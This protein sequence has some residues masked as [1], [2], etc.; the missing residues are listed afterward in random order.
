MINLD[1]TYT[2]NVEAPGPDYTYGAFRNDSSGVAVDGTPIERAFLND[3]NG[4]FQSLMVEAGI[5]PSNSPETVGVS[6]IKDALKAIIQAD[7]AVPIATTLVA[8]RSELATA[9]EAVNPAIND[10]VIT[11]LGLAALTSSTTRKGLIQTATN[12]NSVDGI[13][14]TLA[15]TPAGLQAKLNTLTPTTGAVGLTKYADGSHVVDRNGLGITDRAVTPDALYNAF[16]GQ[17]LSNGYMVLPGGL[18]ALWG[19]TGAPTI[20]GGSTASISHTFHSGGFPV[21]AFQVFL[22]GVGGRGVPFLTGLTAA[23]FSASVDGYGVSVLASGIA[24][25]AIGY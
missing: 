9:A 11:P 16:T 5:V 21:G 6:Q 25:L 10:R 13:S 3:I 4:F 24:Y 20:T 8:G 19:R 22:Q 23:N 17:Q 1:L 14:T 18:R 15:V 2:P 7:A 12:N